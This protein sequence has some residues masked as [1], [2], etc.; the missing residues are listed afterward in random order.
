MISQTTG[1]VK[2]LINLPEPPTAIFASNDFMALQVMDVILKE[3]YRIPEDFSII[4]FD[5][6]PI[7]SHKRIELT[8]IDSNTAETSKLAI[9]TLISIIN[10]KPEPVKITKILVEP[11]LIIRTSTGPAKSG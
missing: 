6:I 7:A 1:A 9:E 4:G 5:D 2:N 11:K 8:T 10:R 3:G